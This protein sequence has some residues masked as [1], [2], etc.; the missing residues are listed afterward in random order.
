MVPFQGSYDVALLEVILPSKHID[1]PFK[2]ERFLTS[3]QNA[4]KRIKK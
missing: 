1:M 3:T 4:A 2:K